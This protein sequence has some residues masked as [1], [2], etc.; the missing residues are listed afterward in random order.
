MEKKRL[1]LGGAIAI[2]IALILPLT[3]QAGDLQPS[4]PPAPTMKTMDNVTPTWSQKIAGAERFE[5]VLDEF[6]VL[7]KETGLVWQRRLYLEPV[8][9]QNAILSCYNHH[10]AGRKGWHLPTIDQLASLID[11][12]TAPPIKLPAGHPFV[13]VQSVEYWSSTSFNGLQGNPSSAWLLDIST[14]QV[15]AKHKTNSFYVWCVRGG[16]SPNS[17]NLYY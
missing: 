4:A 1:I 2:A 14:G 7:D 8:P 5:L 15:N 16:Q 13:N 6:G 11:L 9:W 12:F 10:E 3:V 17:T